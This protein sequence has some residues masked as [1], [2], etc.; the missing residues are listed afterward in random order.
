V[1]QLS[2]TTEKLQI[3]PGT[4]GGDLDV[5]VTYTDRSGTT[6]T[7]GT[8]PTNTIGG[9]T[10]VDILTLA[11][12]STV[13]RVRWLSA[14]NTSA[15]VTSA[16]LITKV[17]GA[18]V[19]ELFKTTLGPGEE[20]VLN[21]NGI[22]FVYASDGS[23]K[24]SN[25]PGRLLRI[26]RYAAAG[27]GNHVIGADC[28]NMYV[29]VVGGGAAGGGCTS[30]ASAAGA[31]GGGGSGAKCERYWANVAPSS[32]FPYTV[33]AAGVGASGAVGGNGAQSTFTG[34]GGVVMTAPGGTGGALGTAATTL[35]ARQGGDG[36]ALA[37]NGDLNKGGNPGSPGIVVVPASAVG[38]GGNGGS[39]QFGD[40][41]LGSTTAGNGAAATGNGAGGAGAFTGASAVRT[42]GNGSPGAV[43]VEEYS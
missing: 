33:G 34:P 36:G 32:S 19:T 3:T 13:R 1:I 38:V 14:R 7:P 6:D 22:W 37:S 40:G 21:G 43:I 41:G 39:G 16:Y 8:Q 23:V 20:L 27:S 18:A 31:G 17:V 9:T 25:Q 35:T 5:D 10:A 42:G 4:T 28:N 26:T 24:A 11:A 29:T 2:G 12:A 15:T 30:V